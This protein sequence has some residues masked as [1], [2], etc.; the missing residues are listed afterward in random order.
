MV[1]MMYLTFTLLKVISCCYD[2][3]SLRHG[4]FAIL[5]I[6]GLA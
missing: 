6:N 4:K 2:R 3:A 5:T 1:P